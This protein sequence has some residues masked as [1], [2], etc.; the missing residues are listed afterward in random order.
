M[1]FV[2]FIIWM[3]WRFKGPVCRHRLPLPTLPVHHGRPGCHPPGH[4]A[5]A[6]HVV[7][8]QVTMS[9]MYTGCIWKSNWSRESAI[10]GLSSGSQ[11]S[12]AVKVFDS[13]PKGSVFDS[14]FTSLPSIFEQDTLT[15]ALWR[16]MI[17][18]MVVFTF[19][20]TVHARPWQFPVGPKNVCGLLGYDLHVEL[21]NCRGAP[22]MT[23]WPM[24]RYP[25]SL[26]T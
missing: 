20:L 1:C 23:K 8:L 25:H 5:P 4:P 12:E 7:L 6:G 13:W 18:M 26:V 11:V 3:F 21:P 15:L 16:K 9:F 2:V 19:A 14:I 24:N 10:S 17:M 22:H